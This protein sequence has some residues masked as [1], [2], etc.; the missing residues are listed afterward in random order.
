MPTEISL[1]LSAARGGD[2]DAFARAY[3]AAYDELRRLARRQLRAMRPGDTLVTT[4]LVNEAFLKLV[5][6]PVVYAD[7]THFFALAARA[8]RQILVD[9]ARERGA[10]KRGGDRQQTTLDASQLSVEAI[11]GEMIDLDAALTRLASVDEWLAQ[12]VE[13]R[14]FGGMTEDEIAGA[15]GIAVRTVR[16]DWK[17]ARAFLYHELAEGR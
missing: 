4:A 1:Q 5:R 16:R 15:A 12:L 17:K 8:M 7:R 13:W 10:R 14:F 11:A 2:R 3:A 6:H 9:Y